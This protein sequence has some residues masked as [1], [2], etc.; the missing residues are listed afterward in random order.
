M[1]RGG[2]GTGFLRRRSEEWEERELLE[3]EPVSPV[4]DRLLLF[5]RRRPDGRR[6]LGITGP[7]ELVVLCVAATPLL[8]HPV[9]LGG[10]GLFADRC[11]GCRE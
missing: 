3:G 11:T 8:T 6:T 4:L 5:V 10:Q 9:P 1:S 2:S 7:I